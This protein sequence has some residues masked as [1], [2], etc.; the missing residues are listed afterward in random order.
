MFDERMLYDFEIWTAW[1]CWGTFPIALVKST[2]RC[3][4]A[5]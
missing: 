2:N 3:C 5:A 4:T 1:R